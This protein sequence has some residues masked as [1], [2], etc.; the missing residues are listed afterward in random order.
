MTLVR[1]AFAIIKEHRRTFIIFN[2]VFYGLFVV[3]MIITAVLPH[4]QGDAIDGVQGELDQPG[5]GSAVSA[6]YE[7][8]NVLW[9]AG[10][11]LVVNF[12]IGAL[13]TTTIPSLVVPFFGIA[14]TIYRVIQWGILFAPV[15]GN[16]GVFLPH[17]ITLIIEGQ[18]YLIAAF[19]VWIHGRK[20]LQP[21][22]F[23]LTSRVVGYKAGFKDT[24]TL[25]PLVIILLMIAAI[26]EAIEV[27]FIIPQYV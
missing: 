11:T 23:D 7:S 8:G 14:F 13:L 27:I 12:F 15:D 2:A 18:A 22:H 19:A 17:L 21:R 16:W 9:A 1:N 6:G 4:L 25:Y 5:L 3:A 10:I 26:Y 20:V 24:L